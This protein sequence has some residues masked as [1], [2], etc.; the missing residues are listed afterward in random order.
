M[1]YDYFTIMDEERNHLEEISKTPRNQLHEDMRTTLS[2]YFRHEPLL[3]MIISNDLFLSEYAFL[4]RAEQD[5]VLCR[6]ISEIF[7]VYNSAIKK[8]KSDFYRLLASYTS[9]VSKAADNCA[10]MD[11][12]TPLEIPPMT[13]PLIKLVFREMGDFLEG[14]Y[15]VFSKLLLSCIYIAEGKDLRKVQIMSF[16]QC[17]GE[18]INRELLV[19]AY[20]PKPFGIPLSQWRNI[21][22]HNSYYSDFESEKIVCEF[23]SKDKKCVDM[24]LSDLLLFKYRIGQ[25]YNV[26]KIS[27]AIM[28]IAGQGRVLKY[29]PKLT[30]NH[31]TIMHQLKEYSCS[32]GFFPKQ[33]DSKTTVTRILVSK[34]EE[35]GILYPVTDMASDDMPAARANILAN[36]ISSL[37]KYEKVTVDVF[38]RAGLHI[39]KGVCD[40]NRLAGGI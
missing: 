5:A 18:L 13:K 10:Q 37:M 31:E 8:S 9:E 38:N 2:P 12:I 24:T 1:K 23:G 32:Y 16:G 15:Q 19:D 21:S 33:P 26:H 29:K 30:L 17:V 28:F 6:S 27:H 35:G 40:P 25:F 3:D 22:A 34:D 39:C 20:V 11:M 7:K 14:S 36:K 4:K